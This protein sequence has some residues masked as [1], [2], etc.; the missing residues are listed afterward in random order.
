MTVAIVRG[1]G[2]A[3]VR[4]HS[5]EV[6]PEPQIDDREDQVPP[7]PALT[8]LLQDILFRVLSV[9]E[10]FTQTQEQQQAPVVQDAM[11]QL[12]VDL[13]VQNNVAPPVGGQVAPMVVLKEDD[14][15]RYERF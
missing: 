3:Q 10:G 4:G 11:G 7:E 5:R 2:S 9:L 6:S 15:R 12:P 8:P 1:R 13:A 14:Q